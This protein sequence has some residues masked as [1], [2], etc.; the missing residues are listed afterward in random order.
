MSPDADD[1]QKRLHEVPSPISRQEVAPAALPTAGPIAPRPRASLA[2]EVARPVVVRRYRLIARLHELVH[3]RL[4]I[5][6][7]PAGYG[8]TT[9]LAEFAADC[10]ASGLQLTVC[11]YTA[12]PWDA[13]ATLLLRGITRVLRRRFPAFGERTLHLLDQARAGTSPADA[14]RFA[15]SVAGVLLDELREHVAHYTVLAVDD[16]HLV[17]DSAS[18]RA[19]L[20]LLLDRL[21]EHVRLLLLSRTV[22]ALD[23]G[24]LLLA[25][26]LGGLGPRDLAFTPDELAG[27][28]QQR[29]GIEPEPAL[30]D[31]VYRWSEG[32]IA[33]LV[34]AAAPQ[35]GD[36]R[37]A[38]VDALI[39]TLTRGWSGGTRLH[40]YLTGQLFRRQSAEHREILLAAALP[41]TCHPADLDDVLGRGGSAEA[42]AALERAGVPINRAERGS[43]AYRMH[44]LLRQFLQTHLE[45]HDRSRHVQLRR[46]WGDLLRERGDHAGAV[47]QYL[48][49]RLYD[50]A[51]K[52]LEQIGERWI[53]SGRRLLVEQWLAQLPPS[54]IDKRPRLG[55]CNARLA[56]AQGQRV[57]AVERARQAGFTAQ[58]LKNPSAAARALLLEAVATLGSGRTEEGLQLC[59]QAL[60]RP[61]IRRSKPLL[62]EAYRSLSIA[63]HIRGVPALA[64]EHMKQALSLYEATGQLWDVATALNNIGSAHE[65]LGQ[66]DEAMWCQARALAIRREL[67]D[68]S[69][70]GRNLNNL[71]LLHLYR[72]DY[73]DA[74]A[75]LR[76]ALSLAEKTANARSQAAAGVN[77]GDLLCAQQ[78]WSQ[79]LATY[80]AAI[81]HARGAGDPQW[82]GYAL[83]G[84]AAALLATGDTAGADHAAR[85][86]LELADRS[87]LLEVGG[88]ARVILAAAALAC[89]RRRDAGTLLEAARRVARQTSNKVLLVRAYLWSGQAAFL[90][91]R[92]GEALSCVQ[93]AAEAAAPFGGPGLIAREGPALVPLL[94][95]A[96]SKSVYAELL[97]RA[98]DELDT[99]A[100]GEA[101]E[102][103]APPVAPADV[104]LP[105]VRL[106]LLGKFSGAVAGSS[107][108][109]AIALRSR[110]REMLA[111]LAMHPDGRSREEIGADLWPEAEPG[112]D[113]TLTHTTLHRL[114]QA[115]F[116]EVVALAGSQS[117]IDSTYRINPEIPLAVDALTFE[118]NYQ[119]ARRPGALPAERREYL[120]AAVDTYNGPFF[121][122]CDAE[123][124]LVIRSRLEHRCAR[125]LAQLVDMAWA[126]GDYRS[127]LAWCDRLIEMD[128]ADDAAH[129][130]ALECYARL[131]EPLGAAVHYRRYVRDLAEQG[132]D[133][134][135][136]EVAAI[137][138]RITASAGA[139]AP[140]LN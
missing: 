35:A 91:K 20:E 65:Q 4:T 122:E 98:L 14:E 36:P 139:S 51:A 118:R 117:G 15:A 99:A 62:A 93:V 97:A 29:F 59:L 47:A 27:Y 30:V 84:E 58:R 111:Y 95:L 22:P 60:E 132:S 107:I 128:F 56:F 109:S 83:T 19:A 136:P 130:R 46:R 38:P 74:E 135:A 92:W 39:T 7:A 18:V 96:A 127:C 105:D 138:Q 25:D 75:K 110:G 6:V 67:C 114:R 57:L 123:W 17:D 80:N 112:Q 125:A 133:H 120:T 94:K 42:L 70:V 40:E 119:A 69:G 44:A 54:L 21:P 106:K 24:R 10:A 23:T 16:Y 43:A 63:E 113:V 79:A 87:K 82:Q 13:D 88:H 86:A 5:V 49:A 48:A 55:L 100:A 64:L 72:G 101:R 1:H 81:A 137:F 68:L 53:D 2:T 129:C 85:Q 41:D 66:F 140:A 103:S 52:V 124:A 3:R 34:L 108:K 28:L 61:A 73:A 89:G 104:P 33:G 115:I 32:W 12:S 76:E 31:E 131:G 121:P 126:D 8:K 71:G 9:L 90:R 45:Q 37:A 77:L 50:R 134:P 78:Q 116:P 102:V 26:Q 11:A